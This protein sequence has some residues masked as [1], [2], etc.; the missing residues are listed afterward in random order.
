[1]GGSYSKSSRK[2]QG[3]VIPLLFMLIRAE[4]MKPQKCDRSPLYHNEKLDAAQHPAGQ[5]SGPS[6]VTSQPGLAWKN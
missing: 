4:T 5:P 2:M 3:P 6:S 1:M